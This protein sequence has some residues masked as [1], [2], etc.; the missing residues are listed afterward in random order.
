MEWNPLNMPAC[1]GSIH[2][3]SVIVEEYCGHPSLGTDIG[4][5]SSQ[6]IERLEIPGTGGRFS[7]DND[8][9]WGFDSAQIIS[10]PDYSGV[11]IDRISGMRFVIDPAVR[12]LRFGGI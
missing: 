1:K 12:T 11:I 10:A 4:C 3:S 2:Y 6:N 8:R 7:D 9:G 5:C